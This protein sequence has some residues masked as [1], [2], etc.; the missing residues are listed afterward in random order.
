M[1]NSTVMPNVS[2]LKYFGISIILKV[3]KNHWLKLL[4]KL[5]LKISFIAL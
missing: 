1:A 2:N 5:L 4:L 3:F